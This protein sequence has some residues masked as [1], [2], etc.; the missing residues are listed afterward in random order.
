MNARILRRL[1]ALCLLTCMV[2]FC[3]LAQDYKSLLGKW[4]MTSETDSDPVTWTLV[5]KDTDGKLIGVLMA[6]DNEMIAQGFS[7]A[8]GILKFKAPYQGEDYT[9]ELKQ[10]GEKLIGGWI[11]GGNS[12]RT[13]GKKAAPKG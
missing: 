8:E 3:A 10:S 11:G 13:S 7:Y 1:L 4:E 6:G 12:G 9:I 5:L 2:A